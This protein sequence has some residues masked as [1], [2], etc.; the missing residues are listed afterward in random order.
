MEF[1]TLWR[2]NQAAKIL[3]VSG[4]IPSSARLATPGFPRAGIS[5]ISYDGNFEGHFNRVYLVTEAA[6]R[7]VAL[8]FVDE[9]PNDSGCPSNGKNWKT[10]NFIN[11]RM[12]ASD[13]AHADDESSKNGDVIEITTRFCQFQKRL[14]RSESRWQEKENTKLLIPVPFARIILHCTQIGLGKSF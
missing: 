10:Y 1:A 5:Y 13:L 12:R 8:Q 11:S 2:A 4:T 6:N 7:I 14:R 3:G 9:H